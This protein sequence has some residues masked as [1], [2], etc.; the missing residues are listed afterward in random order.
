MC[1]GGVTTTQHISSSELAYLQARLPPAPHQQRSVM[2]R[3]LGRK[4]LER[5]CAARGA[6]RPSPS[7]TTTAPNASRGGP[8]DAVSAA[9]P[10]SVAAEQDAGA[11][12]GGGVGAAGAAAPAVAVAAADLPAATAGASVS[13]AAAVATG[14]S[15]CPRGRDCVAARSCAG[16]PRRGRLAG[17]TLR[18]SARPLWH[19]ASP[20]APSACGAHLGHARGAAI[21]ATVIAA[22]VAAEEGGGG[23]GGG[24]AAAAKRARAERAVT[25]AAAVAAP[26]AGAQC[27]VAA[28]KT[29]TTAAVGEGDA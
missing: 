17:S 9:A 19:A 26:V 2:C 3:A 23:G 4:Q 21:A 27:A 6:R 20:V 5:R 16:R 13:A 1:S 12:D 25:A 22:A 15:G 7:A 18:P 14:T 29:T 10:A 28:S 11:A 8:P 24:A